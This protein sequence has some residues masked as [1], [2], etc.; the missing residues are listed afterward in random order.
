[1]LWILLIAHFI[2]SPE[3]YFFFLFSFCGAGDRV[4]GY[5]LSTLY[6]WGTFPALRNNFWDK[7][8]R[9]RVLLPK[10]EDQNEAW[11]QER[12]ALTLALPLT[13]CVILNQLLKPSGF[14]FSNVRLDFKNNNYLVVFDSYFQLFKDVLN[15]LSNCQRNWSIYSCILYR[16]EHWVLKELLRESTAFKRCSSK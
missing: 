10:G 14:Q 12:V 11:R 8:S 2:F 3:Q 6:C 9:F 7:G 1:M 4:Q 5:M 13:W 15:C 16:L